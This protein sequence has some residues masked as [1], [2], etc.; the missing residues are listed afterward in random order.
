MRRFAPEATRWIPAF[1]G[2]TR[3]MVTGGFL[4]E[5]RVSS[6]GWEKFSWK[7]QGLSFAFRFFAV[8]AVLVVVVIFAFAIRRAC[9]G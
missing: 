9:R 6:W 7:Q 1:A 3:G 4:L 2:M 8:A 5:W